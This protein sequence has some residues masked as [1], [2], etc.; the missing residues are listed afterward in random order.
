MDD[1]KARARKR[2][3]E[4]HTKILDAPTEPNT[5]KKKDKKRWC[6]GKEGVEHK[7]QCMKYN[8]VK[9][10]KYSF[11][12]TW[13][14]LVCTECGKELDYHYPHNFTNKDPIPVPDWVDK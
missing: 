2:H 6:R 5:S 7:L 10:T 9:H 11:G 8:E 13:R 14:L 4:R 1:W 12:E 3:D